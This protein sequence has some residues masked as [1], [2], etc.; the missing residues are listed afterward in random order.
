[1]A[2]GTEL[3]EGDGKDDKGDDEIGED[4]IGFKGVVGGEGEGV[5]DV[6]LQVDPVQSLQEK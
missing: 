2:T 3:D 6:P 4:V 1:M 5:G